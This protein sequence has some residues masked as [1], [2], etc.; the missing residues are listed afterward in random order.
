VIHVKVGQ[1]WVDNDPR[2]VAI[3]H[4]KVEE[5]KDGKARCAVFYGRRGA[6]WTKI[7]LHRF[8]PTSNG[9]RLVNEAKEGEKNGHS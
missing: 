1:V 5:I 7:S 2:V 8:K 3:R 4:L 9:Y 6:G